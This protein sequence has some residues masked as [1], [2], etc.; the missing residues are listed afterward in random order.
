V[1][2]R[3]RDRTHAGD[4]LAGSLSGYC[5]NSEVTVLGLARGGV[6]VAARVARA[7]SVS[8]DVLVVRKLGVPWAPEMAFGALGPGGVRV[9]NDDVAAVLSA[10]DIAAV[11]ATAQ[12]ELDRQERR[13]RADRP[14][15]ELAGR[16]VILVDDGWATGATAAAAVAVTRQ[17]GAGRVVLAAPVAAAEAVAR[18]RPVADALCCP[19]VPARFGAVGRFYQNFSQVSAAEVSELLG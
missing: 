6:P 12:A 9:L 8:L 16:T 18:L 14:A 5:E 10:E 7:L 2:H 17:L 1:N 13:Y 19:W 3:Y 11:V 4:V 15:L